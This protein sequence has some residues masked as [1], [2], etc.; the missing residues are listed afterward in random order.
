[1]FATLPWPSLE[2]RPYEGIEALTDEALWE[3]CGVRI[4]FTSRAG[5][6]SQPPYD[7]LNT[8]SHVGDDLESVTQNRRIVLQSLGLAD[9]SLIVPNQVHGTHVVRVSGP[10]DAPRAAD[11]A[12]EGADAIVV[13]GSGVAALLNFADCLPLI[14]VSPSGRFAVAH[15]GWRGAV[16]GI[17]GK[18]VRALAQ[19]DAG[20]GVD[21]SM[22]NAYI[23]PHIRSECFE[24]S[25]D[26]ATRFCE[27]YGNDVL[28]DARHV[29]LAR[30]VSEDLMEA[31]LDGARIADAGICTV[32]NAQRYYS[33]R[34]SGGAC[35]R[36]AAFACRK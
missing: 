23:G 35:G 16:A 4:A 9:V 13:S 33:Y 8:A 1:M 22:F 26:V 12:A 14:I 18:A 24:V 5:G 29:S 10:S 31:G 21:A 2:N 20:Q 32:C 28:A 15:A 30:A 3:A 17:A 25:E 6:V 27:R 7:L 19:E 36:H 11:E 34:A